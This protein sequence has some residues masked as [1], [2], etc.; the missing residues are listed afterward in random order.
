[1]FKKILISIA[2]LTLILI[3]FSTLA[4]DCPF[5][6]TNCEYPGNCGRY[7][8]VNEDQICDHSQVKPTES[9]NLTLAKI[10][11]TDSVTKQNL[12][13][14][15]RTY[16]LL[17][18]TVALT[19]AYLVSHI[20]TK[21]QK[22]SLP[23]HRKFWNMLLLISFLISALLGI[24]LVIKINFGININLSLNPLFWHVEIGIAMTIISIFHIIWHWNYFKNYFTSKK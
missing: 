15:S 9:Q 11:P 17:P 7:M 23:A 19:L 5:G 18:I 13:R 24:W 3:P 16:H 8:D 1:M 20:L 6:E 4:Q 14:N 21:K 2:F 10:Q 12:N 22:I